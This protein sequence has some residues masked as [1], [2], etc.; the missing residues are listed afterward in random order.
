MAKKKET[1]TKARSRKKQEVTED[2]PE[3]AGSSKQVKP[4]GTTSVKSGP[5]ESLQVEPFCMNCQYFRPGLMGPTCGNPAVSEFNKRVAD[6]HTSEGFKP[7]EALLRKTEVIPDADDD[8]LYDPDTTH[9]ASTFEKE[10]D[11]LID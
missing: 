2:T 3:V 4:I 7:K 1:E 10:D 5:S 8:G 6:K 9:D 11:G